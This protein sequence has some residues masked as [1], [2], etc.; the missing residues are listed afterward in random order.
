M[1]LFKFIVIENEICSW[2]TEDPKI[3]DMMYTNSDTSLQKCFDLT[4]KYKEKMAKN[5]QE[6]ISPQS[7]WQLKNE[8]NEILLQDEVYGLKYEENQFEASFI[9]YD[10]QLERIEN[11]QFYR[12]R[13]RQYSNFFDRNFTEKEIERIHPTP[14]EPDNINGKSFILPMTEKQEDFNKNTYLEFFKPNVSFT[15]LIWHKRL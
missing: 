10:K 8:L 5:L 15:I 4:L 6:A 11:N 2:W 1:K 7:L 14:V 12:Q 9:I 3:E 13:V